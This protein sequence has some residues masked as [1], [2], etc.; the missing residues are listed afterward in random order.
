MLYSR[1]AARSDQETGAAEGG[2]FFP[3][4][5]SSRSWFRALWVSQRLIKVVTLIAKSQI[6]A[7]SRPAT[8]GLRLIHL[9]ERSSTLHGRASMG[10]PAIQFSRSRATAAAVA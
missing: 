1:L 4:R 10:L 5:C 3:G 9:A 7:K 6:M 2:G 8:S